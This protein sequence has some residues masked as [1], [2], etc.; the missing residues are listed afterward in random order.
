[1]QA[2]SI[3]IAVPTA[4]PETIAELKSEVDEIVCLYSP[5]FFNAVGEAYRNFSQTTDE[6]VSDL[7]ERAKRYL[8]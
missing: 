4:S 2:H 7:L 3:H 1:L 5:D 6:E 8:S